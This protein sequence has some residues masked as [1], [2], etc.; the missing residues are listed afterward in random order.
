MKKEILCALMCANLGFGGE[1][2]SISDENGVRVEC[3][4]AEGGAQASLLSQLPL[5]VDVENYADNEKVFHPRTR[6]NTADTAPSDGKSGTLAYFAPWDNI[7]LFFGDAGPYN[8]LFHLGNVVKGAENI[9][10]LKGKI[11]VE[12]I[13]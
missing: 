9:K 11:R 13:K 8:G 3:E 2:I 5:E 12:V 7:V 6:L 10:N 4:L 1:L